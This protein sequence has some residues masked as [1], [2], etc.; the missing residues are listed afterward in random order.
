LSIKQVTIG[1][2]GYFRDGDEAAMASK[3]LATLKRN[4]SGGENEFVKR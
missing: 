4:R 2:K 1:Q 3:K